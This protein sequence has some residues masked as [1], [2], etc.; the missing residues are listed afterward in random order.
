MVKDAPSPLMTVT[1]GADRAF[2]SVRACVARSS[3]LTCSSSRAV[4][5]PPVRLTAGFAAD[6]PK[7]PG[8][9]VAVSGAAATSE[10]WATVITPHLPPGR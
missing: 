10:S 2:V 6:P 8:T 5:Q 1:F 7:L 9:L 4:P 3:R